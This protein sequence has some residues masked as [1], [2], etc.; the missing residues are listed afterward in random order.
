M[1]FFGISG[2]Q[3]LPAQTNFALRFDRPVYTVA[4]GTTF[5]VSVL[6]DPLPVDG[7]FSFGARLEFNP[8]DA[9][10]AGTGSISTPLPLNFN[11]VRGSGA[12]KASATGVGAVKGTVD[13]ST[14]LIVPHTSPALATFLVT[15]QG[16]GSYLLQLRLFN[17]L[18]PSEDIFVSGLGTNLDP[19]ITFSTAVVYHRP[20]I[21]VLVALHLNLQTGLFE[22]TLRV[23]N[24][25]LEPAP[26][27]RLLFPGLPANVT[28][29]NASGTN[30]G[31]P[32]LHYNQ[33]L[34]GGESVD[35]RA[36]FLVADRRLFPQPATQ[37]EVT[38]PQPESI[39]T[40]G[41][42]SSFSPITRGV[43]LADGSFLVEFAA[44]PT[45]TYAIQYSE[46]L[47]HWRQALPSIRG[48]GNRIQWIDNGPPKTTA[49]PQTQHHRFYRLVILP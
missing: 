15:D 34:A 42:P 36:E 20:R 18:G 32:F 45:H 47:Q 8:A 39:G 16:P 43:P 17:T 28:L 11:G 22:E 9:R 21:E 41:T 49:L 38:F 31:I 19:L 1:L 13:F 33:P 3:T 6:I 30:A 24:D 25:D 35:L 10:I 7:V 23:W 26:S 29:Y 46:D 5:P 40:N 2:A 12:V 37:A 14:P 27:L 44:S 4:R 48:Q